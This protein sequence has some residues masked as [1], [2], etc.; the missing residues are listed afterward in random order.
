M[1]T[2]DK[3]NFYLAKSG[4][5][6]ADL[7]RSLGLSNSIY[8]QWNTRKSRP[9]ND[10]LPAIACFLGVAVEDLLPDFPEGDAKK[11]AAPGEEDELLRKIQTLNEQERR[12][13]EKYL[14]F[15]SS[16]REKP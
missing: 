6:G 3:I 1:D 12:D 7:S 13:V 9:R 8:S 15:L 14:D 5:T 2:I 16:L 10:R 11:A 4:K